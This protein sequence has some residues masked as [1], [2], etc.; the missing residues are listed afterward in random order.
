MK[1][2]EKFLDLKVMVSDCPVQHSLKFIG[3]KWKIGIIWSLKAEKRRFGQLKKDVLGISEKMLI[4]ELKVLEKLGM[5]TKHAYYEIPP[6]VEY[7]LT[8]RGMTLVPVIEH[9]V[10][11]GYEDMEYGSN[12]ALQENI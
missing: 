3:G 2:Q 11:W 8:Q 12:F 6:R 1:V 7:S 9:I 5:I 10:H 4:Q